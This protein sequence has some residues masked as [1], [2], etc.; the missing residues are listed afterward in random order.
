MNTEV[1][2][3]MTLT[4]NRALVTSG[5]RTTGPILPW[6]LGGLEFRSRFIVCQ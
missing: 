2:N 3:T 4:E 5:Q 6:E 1:E